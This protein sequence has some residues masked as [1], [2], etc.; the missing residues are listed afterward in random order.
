MS[1][2]LT[3]NWYARCRQ[4]PVARAGVQALRRT[5]DALAERALRID[6]SEEEPRTASGAG[7]FG[8]S[9][10]Y[11]ALDYPLLWRYLA[12]IELKPDDVAFEIGCGLGR[13]LCAI[14]RWRVRKVV[15]VEF[16]ER[17]AVRARENVARL[18][19]RRSPVE[20]LA[21]DAAFVDY[22]E[23]TVFYLFNPFGPTTMQ[24]VLDR[25]HESVRSNPRRVRL[26][27][28]N[29]VHEDVFERAT[30]LR[31]TRSL[32]SRVFRTRATLWEHA[33]AADSKASS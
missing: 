19:G 14:A 1:A 4:T 33:P 18:R 25:I 13:A 29:P 6:T 24:I 21:A 22:T 31:K 28:V 3:P 8:D 7:A 20:V 11:S 15:G 27:Y 32:D 9:N 30:W 10:Y 23:G 16:S 17:L 2:T 12:E 26:L 5:I